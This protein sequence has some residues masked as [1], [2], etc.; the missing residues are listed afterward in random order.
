[1]DECATI[2]RD[3]IA[4]CTGNLPRL[5]VNLK[6]LSLEQWYAEMWIPWMQ[7]SIYATSPDPLEAIRM[8]HRGLIECC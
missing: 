4:R 5:V 6:Q 3:V 1:M 2:G 8:V 7:R